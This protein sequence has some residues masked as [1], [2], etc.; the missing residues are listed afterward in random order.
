MAPADALLAACLAAPDADLPRL[1]YADALDDLG[2]DAYAEFVRVQVAVAGTPPWQPLAVHVRHRRP[3]LGTGRPFRDRLP[4]VENSLLGWA[5]EPFRRGL[6]WAVTVSQLNELLA[7]GD[8]LADLAPVGELHLPTGPL[9]DEW[10]ALAARPWLGR[11]RTLRFTGLA[12]PI[13]PVRVF[14]DVPGGLRELRFDQ[15]NSPA[16]GEL[17]GGLARS[18]LGRQ[19]TALHLRNGHPAEVDELLDELASGPLRVGALSLVQIGLTARTAARLAAGPLL[20]AVRTLDLTNSVALNDA[21]VRHL[22]P[23]RGDRRLDSLTLAN[24]GL[25]DGA[26][27]WLTWAAPVA[28]LKH[29]DLSGNPN[30]AGSLGGFGREGTPAGLRALGLRQCGLTDPDVKP[31]TR[32]AFWPALVELDLRFNQ[33]GNAGALHLVR[34]DPPPDLTALLLT[35]NPIHEPLRQ[36]LRARYGGAVVFGE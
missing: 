28:G 18:P 36:R 7:V 30:V 9:R 14:G 16:A 20:D 29:L 15:A 32:A 19:L 10:A 2:D 34:A 31:L 23:A 4:A 22:F 12:L 11:V 27:R 21:G 35:G 6:G 8:R 24:C 33:I 1:A 5:A 26:V 3:D 25:A 13:E 17:L